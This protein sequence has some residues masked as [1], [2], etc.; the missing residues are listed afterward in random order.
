AIGKFEEWLEHFGTNDGR[1]QV[2]FDLASANYQGGRETNALALFTTFV[3]E[4][5]TNQM[6]PLAQKWVADYYFRNNDL[7]N[8]ESHYQFLFQNTNWP[9]SRLSYEAQMNAGRVAIARQAYGDAEK[10]F[11]LL[12][13]DNNAPADVKAEAY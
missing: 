3:V 10:Y 4:F 9:P 12:I 6:A 11:N 2:E 5:P 1:P 8:A 7:T 13:E